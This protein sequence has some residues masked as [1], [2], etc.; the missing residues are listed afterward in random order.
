[1]KKRILWGLS[2]ILLL[3]SFGLGMGS[4]FA[5]TTT[6]SSGGTTSQAGFMYMQASPTPTF[7]AV[8]AGDTKIVIG[9][10]V[11]GNIILTMPSGAIVTGVV[12]SDGTW[13]YQVPSG[14]ALTAGQVLSAT[15]QV[16]SGDDA[17]M[18]SGAATITVAATILGTATKPT[19]SAVNAGDTKVTGTVDTVVAGSHVTVTFANDETASGD[20]NFDGTWSVVV[21]G[22]VT[23]KGGDSLSVVQSSPGYYNSDV[24]SATVVGSQAEQSA[25]PVF[26]S[27][28]AGATTIS[29]TGVPGAT[30]TVTLPDGKT[31]VSATVASDGTWKGTVPS[32]VSLSVGQKVTAVQTEEGKTPSEQA[33]VVVESAK[34]WALP[35]TGSESFIGLAIIVLLLIILALLLRESSDK[36]EKGETN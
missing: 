14:T 4:S 19:I 28:V 12:G 36:K 23:L 7:S 13:T 24:A 10:K 16:G 34:N 26:N 29:G 17:E 11:G 15:Q 5:D 3:A 1:M 20:V 9:G 33:A 2:L 32:G 35:F 21:P 27:V 25:T 22:D 8:Q 6:S 31:T 18:V 30:I